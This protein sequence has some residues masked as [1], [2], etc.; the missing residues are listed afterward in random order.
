M[1]DVALGAGA[2]AVVQDLPAVVEVAAEDLLHLPLALVALRACSGAEVPRA[3]GA[4]GA[5][6]PDVNGGWG[7]EDQ[8]AAGVR[9]GVRRHR[10]HV[11]ASADR[12]QFLR[13][14]HRACVKAQ[15]SE[16]IRR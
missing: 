6:N 8:R 9:G 14:D 3:L 2:A 16:I 5:R 4:E 7:W 10:L 15:S 1:V 11:R 13:I 12:D